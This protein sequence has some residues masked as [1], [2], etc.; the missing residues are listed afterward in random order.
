MYDNANDGQAQTDAVAQAIFD[1]DEEEED[2]S[3]YMT[4]RSLKSGF[5]LDYGN[6]SA[7]CTLSWA[8][9]LRQMKAEFKEIGYAQAPK[10]T[11]SR[12]FDLSKKF[13]LFSDN[14]HPQKGKKR[15]LLIGCNYS[16]VPDAEL[17][18]SHDDIRSMKV[19]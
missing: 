9:L 8:E 11:T 2:E 7:A 16:N 10:L 17:K 19:R 6:M 14:Y 12:K 1:E 4:G 5:S 18:A 15:S 3:T 13:S